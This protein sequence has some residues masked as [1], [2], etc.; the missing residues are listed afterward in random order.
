[1]I[2][3]ETL[4]KN[5]LR[6]HA[7]VAMTKDRVIGLNGRLPWHLPQELKLFKK[8]TLGHPII[9]GR[10]TF[11][12]L[13]HQRPLPGRRNIVIS[14]TLPATEG[15]DR[16]ANLDELLHL[17]LKGDAFVIGGARLFASTFSLCE[18]IYLTVINGDYSGDTFLPPFEDDFRFTETLDRFPEFEIQR[19]QQRRPLALEADNAEI[20]S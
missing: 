12:S 4:H 11:E 18:S 10:A 7:V 5:G 13:P 15:V 17:N 20:V 19:Y 3:R 9:M 2:S 16:L 8:R 6:L 14:R 1:M